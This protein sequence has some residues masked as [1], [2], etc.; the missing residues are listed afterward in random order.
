MQDKLAGGEALCTKYNSPTT[1]RMINDGLRAG[2]LEQAEIGGYAV[3]VC[4]TE[5]GGLSCHNA[6]A[7]EPGSPPPKFPR[8]PLRNTVE[9]GVPVQHAAA[10]QPIA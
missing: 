7:I 5:L 9:G 2:E 8:C 4:T 3:G 10:D 6:V 1:Q